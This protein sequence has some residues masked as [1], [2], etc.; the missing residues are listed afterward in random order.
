M[1]NKMNF[2][3]YYGLQVPLEPLLQIVKCIKR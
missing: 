3:I 1:Q 2:M